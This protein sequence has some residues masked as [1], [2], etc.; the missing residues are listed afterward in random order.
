MTCLDDSTRT[1]VLLIMDMLEDLYA[2]RLYREATRLLADA[3]CRTCQRWTENPPWTPRQN[4]G[5][6][7]RFGTPHRATLGTDSCSMWAQRRE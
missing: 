1:R 2:A 5:T 7:W 4:K 6:C 3:C